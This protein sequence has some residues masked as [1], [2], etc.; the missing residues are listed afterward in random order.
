MT[1]SGAR[2]FVS[3]VSIRATRSKIG[4]KA[5]VTSSSTTKTTAA[6][7]RAASSSCVSR[8]KGAARF[9]S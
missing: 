3:S 4:T 6:Y 1:K 9:A 2:R 8:T 5:S 7:T